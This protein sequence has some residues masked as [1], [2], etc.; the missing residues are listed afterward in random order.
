MKSLGARE[1]NSCSE[2]S[3]CQPAGLVRASRNIPSSCVAAEGLGVLPGAKTLVLP[4]V[5]ARPGGRPQIHSRRSSR[6]IHRS[7]PPGRPARPLAL[8][9]S[10]GRGS[11]RSTVAEGSRQA[12]GHEFKRKPLL[13]SGYASP[14]VD[15]R[16]CNAGP[17]DPHCVGQRDT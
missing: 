3:P 14:S 17:Q 6:P 12:S 4:P 9:G 8:M 7:V 1:A 10:Q 5:A 13:L 2:G 16:R 15:P 11:R